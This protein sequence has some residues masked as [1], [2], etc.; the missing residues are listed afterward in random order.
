V[1]GR[2]AGTNLTRLLDSATEKEQLLRDGGLAGVRVTDD[3]K[4]AATV[5]LLLVVLFH[6]GLHGWYA[7]EI[8]AKRSSSPF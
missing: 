5:D 4:G 8:K 1:P 6:I 3:G 7:D 2:L